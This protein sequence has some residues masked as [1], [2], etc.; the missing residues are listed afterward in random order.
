MTRVPTYAFNDPSGVMRVFR[1]N[2][3][4]AFDSRFRTMRRI[5][6][7]VVLASGRI[8]SILFPGQF[9]ENADFPVPY[10]V[11]LDKVPYIIG[12]SKRLY[13]DNLYPQDQDSA[14]PA[15]T[16]TNWT[17]PK[18]SYVPSGGF[19]QLYFGFG[20]IAK[21]DELI[22]SNLDPTDG[23]GAYDGTRYFAYTI[24][25]NQVDGSA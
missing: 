14:N 5:L 2:G 4:V 25:E 8:P 19:T 16:A 22:V 13:W 18:V 17:G 9:V 15:I 3:D 21:L 7:G 10:G 1:D 6:T 24:F 20:L 12:V 11:T 23:T